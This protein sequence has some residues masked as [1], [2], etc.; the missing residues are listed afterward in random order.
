MT[1]LNLAT[2]K[3]LLP[4]TLIILIFTLASN[5]AVHPP[6]GKSSPKRHTSSQAENSTPKPNAAPNNTPRR[7]HPYPELD[8]MLKKSQSL[9]TRAFTAGE[10]L[11]RGHPKSKTQR[12]KNLGPGPGYSASLKAMK[13]K[14]K[15]E[16]RA[17]R[18]KRQ[19]NLASTATT[20][21]SAAAPSA[22]GSTN[23]SAPV[24]ILDDVYA[25][26]NFFDY[27]AFYNYKDPTNG[28]VEYVTA[29]E[30]FGS[31]LAYVQKDNK[32]IMKADNTTVLQN[33][34]PRKSVRIE[35]NK[36]YTGGLFILDLER[37][38]YGCGVWPAFWTTN[39]NWPQNGEIDIYE[40][41]HLSTN[42]QMT[43]HTSP[44]CNLKVPG[45]FTGYVNS[46]DCNALINNNEGCAI[47]DQSYSSSGATLKNIG[48]GAFAVKWDTTGI[49]VWF[50]PRA[51]IPD[52]IL[53]FTPN[54]ALWG[55]PQA[56]LSP[57]NC[58]IVQHFQE[59]KIIFNITFCGD[60][61][62]MTYLTSGCPGTCNDQIMNP[63]N[64]NEAIWVIN[65]LR[66]YTNS[67]LQAGVLN[68]GT[69]WRS[70]KNL[71]WGVVMS[72]LVTF[73]GGWI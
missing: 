68:A 59:H 62:G 20:S 5:A 13:R 35:T 19:T 14:E 42:N 52:D 44:G 51:V 34:Q 10:R 33:G 71:L 26:Q 73:F 21:G 66:T 18:Q 50:F 9:W 53:E 39:A 17:Q 1:K 23:S 57:D 3:L 65:S 15:K 11:V 8:A 12:D 40:G 38:P 43:W 63:A 25:G 36:A 41:V 67:D 2:Q 64:I 24:W 61:A 16:K 29:D 56:H 7:A 46:T 49:S 27:F 37:G 55:Q 70:G 47:T 60:W 31:Q 28:L 45:G 22:T 6:I 54:P 58:D 69:S 4:I 30:A 32:V 48:G 72:L